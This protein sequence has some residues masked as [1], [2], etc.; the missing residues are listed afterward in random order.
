MV[1]LSLSIS[2]H[3]HHNGRRDM[4]QGHWPPPTCLQGHHS[5]YPHHKQRYDSDEKAGND[6]EKGGNDDDKEGG[7]GNCIKGGNSGMKD[8]NGDKEKHS[9]PVGHC[10]TG[11]GSEDEI[12][13]HPSGQENTHSPS[14]IEKGTGNCSATWRKKV[15]GPFFFCGFTNAKNLLSLVRKTSLQ[16]LQEDTVAEA[17]R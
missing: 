10:S 6:D 7:Y 1:Q 9:N 14:C 3:H 5:S 4:L 13:T 2:S 8:G 15:H 17:E 12:S 11:K 16:H